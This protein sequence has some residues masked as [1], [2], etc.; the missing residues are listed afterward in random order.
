V[1]VVLAV[2]VA[3]SGCAVHGEAH[4]AASGHLRR[5]RIPLVAGVSERD[6]AAV[7]TALRRVP[8]ARVRLVIQS[9]A[10]SCA[11]GYFRNNPLLVGAGERFPA[12]LDVSAPS[13]PQGVLARV[14]RMRGV[15]QGGPVE[16]SPRQ[17]APPAGSMWWRPGNVTS[18]LIREQYAKAPRDTSVR[19]FLK[20]GATSRQVRRVLS[21]VHGIPGAT[22]SVYTSKAGALAR[23]RHLFKD[24]QGLFDALPGNPFPAQVQFHIAKLPTID[25]RALQ[26]LPGVS[27]VSVPL[28]PPPCAQLSFTDLIALL[29]D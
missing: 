22:K 8:G 19:V 24:Q 18:C 3:A 15:D 28:P 17:C 12:E 29:A 11:R 6:V 21:L 14:E 16:S 1:G 13:L 27:S 26:R 5:V 20:D 9:Q 4:R 23:A 25:D 2:V 10:L 7:E